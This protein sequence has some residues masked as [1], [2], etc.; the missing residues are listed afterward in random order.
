ETMFGYGREELLALAIGSLLPQT[1]RGD[2]LRRRTD[3]LAAPWTRETETSLELTARR[4]DGSEFPVAISVSHL[5]TKDG[6]LGVTFVLDISER[7]K[8]EAALLQN[9]QEL[10]RLTARLLAIQEA[11]TQ[12]IARDLHDDLS[13]KLAALGMEASALAKAP[14]RSPDSLKGRIRDLAQ[15]I[16]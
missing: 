7:R 9:Q 8:T 6:P 15:K 5:E 2:N 12:L 14:P 13:Q 11:E 16:S 3:W 4:K 1:Q 10:Q